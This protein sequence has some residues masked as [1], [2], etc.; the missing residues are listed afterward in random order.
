MWC[1]A[2]GC[3]LGFGSWE[4]QASA[5][6]VALHCG[7]DNARQECRLNIYAEN[8]KSLGLH[9]WCDKSVPV[10][11]SVS[12]VFFFFY[13]HLLVE[14]CLPPS[15]IKVCQWFLLVMGSSERSFFNQSPLKCFRQGVR[16]LCPLLYTL[17]SSLQWELLV[18]LDALFKG[19]V[20]M[21]SALP[22]QA[23]FNQNR[24]ATCFNL[25]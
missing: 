9:K 4:G 22:S 1:P 15:A 7:A 25:N 8:A 10:N 23:V 3:L 2:W 20:C 12:S 6:R 24:I 13:T 5:S 16:W 18:V 21:R 17:F 19:V 14:R 11:C